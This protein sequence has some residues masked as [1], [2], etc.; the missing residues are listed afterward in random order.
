MGWRWCTT[1][2]ARLFAIALCGVAL[3]AGIALSPHYIAISK[4]PSLLDV[5]FQSRTLVLFIRIGL[6][7]VIGYIVGSLLARMWRSEWLAK[8]GPF[9]ISDVKDLT[10]DLDFAEGA[11][12]DAYEEIA[13]LNERTVASDRSIRELSESVRVTRDEN[14]DLRSRLELAERVS[15]QLAIALK[16][17]GNG[18]DRTVS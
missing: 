1:W 18:P 14:V 15:E 5:L 7:F 10:D 12:A 16:G 17:S 4:H 11:L 13:T 3:G 8:A 2:P 6:L 9:A